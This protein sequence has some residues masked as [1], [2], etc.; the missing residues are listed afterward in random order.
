VPHYTESGPARRGVFGKGPGSYE[1]PEWEPEKATE[2]RD[3]RGAVQNPD[4]VKKFNLLKSRSLYRFTGPGVFRDHMAPAGISRVLLLPVA[5]PEEKGDGQI[6]EMERIFGGQEDL[7]LGYCL[8]NDCPD[9]DVGRR[10]D[11]VKERFRISAIKIQT[12]VTGI[13]PGSAGGLERLH[14]ILEASRKNALPVVIH[15]GYTREFAAARAEE[16][17]CLDRLQG[18]E[19]GVTD[20]PVVIAHAGFFGCSREEVENNVLSRIT[21]LLD[22]HRH[23]L[24]DT[25]GLEPW[26]LEVVMGRMDEERILFG[27]D[28]LY[29]STG[30]M[31]LRS[32]AAMMRAGRDAVKMFHQIACLNPARVFLPASPPGKDVCGGPE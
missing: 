22:K 25:A 13:D 16:F 18:V 30:N 23:L 26:A 12:A 7:L 10:I 2:D 6:A 4:L 14:L 24:V 5:L 28:A 17:G 8:P 21:A 19:W 32:I 15:G 27:S 20:Q 29:N 31:A 1:P 11:G 3:E 9:A